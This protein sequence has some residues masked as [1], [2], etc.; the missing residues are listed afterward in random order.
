MSKNK[1]ATMIALFLMLAI[2]VS[3][4]SSITVIA[5]TTSTYQTHAFIG[6]LPNP[7]GVGQEVLL[8]IGVQ[9]QLYRV[10]QGWEDMSVT[11]EKPDGT[12]ETIS[13][14]VTDATGGTGRTFVPQKEGTYY[15]QT[16]FPEQVT[17]SSKRAMIGPVGTVMLASDSPKLALVVQAEPIEYYP[18][19][20]LPTEYWT[21]P[22]NA[23]HREWSNVSGS[24]YMSDEYNEA[25]GSPHVLWTRPLTIGGLVGG[26]IGVQSF[27]I[28]DAYQG[29]FSSRVII[30]GVFI[31]MH[32]TNIR[33]R[34][35]TAVDLRTGEVIWEKV[36]GDN[37]TIT[38]PQLFYWDSYNYHG[39]FAYLWCVSGSNWYSYDPFTGEPRYSMTNVPSG[40]T[41]I[42]EKGIIYRYT[43]NLNRQWMALWNASAL[44][45]MR[46]SWSP[47]GG[48]GGNIYA[49]LNASATSGSAGAAATRAWAWNISIPEGLPGSVRGVKL[50]DKVVG[51]DT[52]QSRQEV[53]LWAF[54]LEPGKE[55]RLLYNKTWKFPDSWIETNVSF[56]TYGSSW[57]LT[58]MDANIGLIWA[59]EELMHYA[60]DLN[61]GAFMWKQE[62]PQ[63]THLDTYSIG[64]RIA[65]GRMYTVGQGGMLHCFNATNGKLLWIYNATD[66]YSEFLW[67]NH[68]SEDILFISGGKI[69][70]FHS[71][72]SPINPLFRGAPAI[73]IDA[74]TGEEVWRVDGL[75]R[76][77]DWGGGPIMGDSVIAMYNTYDQRIYAIGKGPSAATVSANPKVST[78]GG[79]VLVEGMVTDVSPGTKNSAV[80][81]RFP[82]GVPAVSDASQG[83][84]MK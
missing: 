84:W 28:G 24:S 13:N 80:M 43:V 23:Q 42:G 17:T 5:Q 3:L 1:T 45:S 81:M 72:H 67:G 35:Y 25:P 37:L 64:R 56:I 40:T 36:L 33:P 27:E 29:K 74:E 34:V 60:F 30:S 83:E 26:D 54:S 22:I 75:F 73:C 15:L 39:T 32:D 79:K 55:G 12:T 57:A 20:P 66:Q 61:T 59:K 41:L 7:V 2:A 78:E 19:D 52:S 16:H 77:T 71:E 8:H 44:G 14:V 53:N 38:T 50:G 47:S 62:I 76:K 68:W 63:Q 11:I 4:V 6:A 69:Y 65:Y 31:Y 21:R 82:N 48:F 51:A 46:G 10:G 58:E 18:P 49:S 70:M 9:E